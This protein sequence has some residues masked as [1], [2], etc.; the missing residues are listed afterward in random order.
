MAENMSLA[1]RAVQALAMVKA[2]GENLDMEH[3]ERHAIRRLQRVAQQVLEAGLNSAIELALQAEDLR[4]LAREIEATKTPN[5]RR[6]R[7]D[8]AS[9]RRV[10]V[11]GGV[12]GLAESTGSRGRSYFLDDAVC[13]GGKC[14]DG[15]CELEGA[16]IKGGAACGD[17]PTRG[18]GCGA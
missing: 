12:G 17:T 1:D 13:T 10:R 18:A 2:M 3:P 6:N 8:A 5:V 14:A 9:S 7:R 16:P 4:T 11:D 15:G